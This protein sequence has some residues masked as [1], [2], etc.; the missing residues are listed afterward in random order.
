MVDVVVGV[1]W[2]SVAAVGGCGAVDVG[3]RKGEKPDG[4][5]EGIL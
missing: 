1:C 5:K 2:G 4:S 3:G